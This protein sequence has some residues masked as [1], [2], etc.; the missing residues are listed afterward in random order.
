MVTKRTKELQKILDEGNFELVE[1]LYS[2]TDEQLTGMVDVRMKQIEYYQR[3]K[4]NYSEVLE[5]LKVIDAYLELKMMKHLPADNPLAD[6]E[7]DHSDKGGY[8]LG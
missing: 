8:T 5:E 7:E 3:N 4:K 2:K 6:I 1:C